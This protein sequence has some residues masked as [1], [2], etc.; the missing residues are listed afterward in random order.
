[1]RKKEVERGPAG[2][3]NKG[4]LEDDLPLMNNGQ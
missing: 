3:V 2:K 1:M 4:A